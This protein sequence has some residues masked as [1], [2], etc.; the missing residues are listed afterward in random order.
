MND[1][2]TTKIVVP[3]DSVRPNP[4]NPNVMSKTMFEKAK[5]IFEEKGMFGSII[6]R[7]HDVD[8][9]YE[10]LDGEHRW[11]IAK[12]LGWTEIP[13]ENGGKLS[14]QEMKFWTVAFNNT[15]GGDDQFKLGELF[16]EIDAGQQQ[17]LPWTQEE[18]NNTKKLVS[19]DF[20]QYDKESE[21]PERTPG[22]LVV[23]PFNAEEAVVWNKA[24][25]ELVKRD[26]IGTDNS[27]KKQDIQA[28]MWMIKNTL[29]VMIGANSD[30]IE[31]EVKT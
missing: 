15:H 13:V 27:K 16:S 31:F 9:Y 1:F 26:L 10:I 4:K 29:G 21:L 7:E 6:V 3:I 19:F 22:Q 8:G 20:S 14:D 17:L 11:K 28:V 30:I 12:E 23:L 18:I 25:D 2:R 5:K 24:K